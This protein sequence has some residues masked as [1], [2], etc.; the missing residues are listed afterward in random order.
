[1]ARAHASRCSTSSWLTT[2]IPPHITSVHTTTRPTHTTAAAGKLTGTRASAAG[3]RTW[4]CRRSRP[5]QCFC[6]ASAVAPVATSKPESAGRVGSKLGWLG[7]IPGDSGT[8][9]P[10]EQLRWRLKYVQLHLCEDLSQRHPTVRLPAAIGANACCGRAGHVAGK[11]MTM[12]AAL[13]APLAARA[14]P[15]TAQERLFIAGA[16]TLLFQR[17]TL[18]EASRPCFAP[19]V[20]ALRT[21][22]RV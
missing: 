11:A 9:S 2:L 6:S 5:S 17:G 22:R 16:Q 18:M 15:R 3:S 21:Q 1:M 14:Q 20:A 10:A 12:L 7:A 13:S 4:Y 8:C 19:L